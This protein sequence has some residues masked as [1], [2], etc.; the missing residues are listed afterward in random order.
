MLE[1][2]EQYFEDG[3]ENLNEDEQYYVDQI[4]QGLQAQVIGDQDLDIYNLRHL[5]TTKYVPWKQNKL[6][7]DQLVSL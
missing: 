6:S 1:G 5:Y 4:V 3:Y 2:I 7:Q